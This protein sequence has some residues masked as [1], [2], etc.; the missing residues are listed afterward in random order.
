MF[1]QYIHLYLHVLCDIHLSTY[2][3]DYMV[4]YMCLW[5]KISLYS[6]SQRQKKNL[7]ILC[8]SEDVF[9][10]VSGVMNE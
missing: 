9:G 5:F 2:I 6:L 10:G 3:C 4:I 1:G 8:V 7:F